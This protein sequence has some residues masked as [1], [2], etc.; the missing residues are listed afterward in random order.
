MNLVGRRRVL[1]DH[2]ADARSLLIVASSTNVE[3]VADEAAA[4]LRLLGADSS[5]ALA[6]RPA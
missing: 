5:V 2:L 1:W 6:E 4:A 3:A